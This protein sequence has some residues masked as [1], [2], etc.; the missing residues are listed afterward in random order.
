M[1]M[2]GRGERLSL[3]AGARLV[4]LQNA[5][6]AVFRL[7]CVSRDV[8]EGNYGRPITKAYCWSCFAA[9]MRTMEEGEAPLCGSMCQGSAIILLPS[10]ALFLSVAVI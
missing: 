1:C 4:I 10:E 6:K 3:T 8:D 9:T 7:C 5:S 2:V